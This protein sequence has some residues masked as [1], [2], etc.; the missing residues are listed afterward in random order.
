MR[1]FGAI[2]ESFVLAMFHTSQDFF[3]RCGEAG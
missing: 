2:V 1:T 3:L